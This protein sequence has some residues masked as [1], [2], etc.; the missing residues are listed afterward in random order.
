MIE[1]TTPPL[2]EWRPSVTVVHGHWQPT[3][4]FSAPKSAH[5]PRQSFC[6]LADLVIRHAFLAIPLLIWLLANAATSQTSA[7]RTS[8]LTADLAFGHADPTVPRRSSLG[9][10]AEHAPPPRNLQIRQ[11]TRCWERR[12]SFIGTPSLTLERAWTPTNKSLTSI[13]HGDDRS[14]RGKA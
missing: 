4:A 9:A 7:T 8:C 6:Y 2:R 5:R 3:V 13:V 1:K 11:A 12:A 10:V 14:G